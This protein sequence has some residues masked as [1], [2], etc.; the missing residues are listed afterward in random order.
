MLENPLQD[1]LVSLVKLKTAHIASTAHTALCL[2]HSLVNPEISYTLRKYFI[3]GVWHDP[4]V[5]YKA[6]EVVWI[7]ARDGLTDGRRSSKR[8]SRT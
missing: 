6:L 8:S 5:I 1:A 2:Y 4:G 7:L 3:C